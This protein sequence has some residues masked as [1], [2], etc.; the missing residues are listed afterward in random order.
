[1][2]VL[3]NKSYYSSVELPL[4][5]VAT[6]NEGPFMLK[7][8]F[9]WMKS[10]SVQLNYFKFSPKTQLKNY[11]VHFF[12]VVP[13]SHF[14]VCLLLRKIQISGPHFFMCPQTLFSLKEKEF[15]L[16]HA[17]SIR[18]L[19]LAK[20]TC[21]SSWDP[22]FSKASRTS[23]CSSNLLSWDLFLWVST[24]PCFWV[25]LSQSSISINV[26]DGSESI[27]EQTL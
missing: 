20:L 7:S 15:H 4:Y 14:G 11:L 18:V 17:K 16:R 27:K 13:N 26:F 6:T 9:F 1:M 19:V 25:L 22:S 5:S 23:C 12:L 3:R 24:W 10:F 2:L 8:E 21:C